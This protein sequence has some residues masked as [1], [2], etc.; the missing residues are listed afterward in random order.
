MELNNE[1]KE[2]V[3]ERLIIMTKCMNRIFSTVKSTEKTEW[4]L[5]VEICDELSSAE[6]DLET[7]LGDKKA[8][9]FGDFN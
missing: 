4:Q 1:V 7:T 6:I 9:V 3:L 2:K 8:D 5:L